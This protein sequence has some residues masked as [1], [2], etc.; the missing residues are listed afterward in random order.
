MFGRAR[1][2][3][4]SHIA[5]TVPSSAV[6][7]RDGLHYVFAVSATQRAQVRLVTVGRELEG[8]TIV[9]SGLSEGERVVVGDR[10]G[11]S[12]GEKVRS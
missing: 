4:G 7:E 10:S 1:F 3:T 5:L 11:L 12:D 8:R 9:L 2:V 6:W